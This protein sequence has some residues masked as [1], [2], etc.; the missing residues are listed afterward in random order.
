MIGGL[1]AAFKVS[2]FAVKALGFLKYLSPALAALSFFKD[3]VINHWK[4]SVIVVLLAALLAGSWIHNREIR[5]LNANIDKQHAALRDY[6][7]T[8]A[9]NK[10][11]LDLC[12]TI[13]N[14]NTNRFIQAQAEGKQAVRRLE[15]QLVEQ[16]A[17]VERIDE[18]T[19]QHRGRDEDCRSL[20]DPLPDWFDDWLR[21]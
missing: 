7:R 1:I 9:I 8:Y 11:S 5:R 18:E 21:E 6:D 17:Q 2:A 15:R 4:L 12:Y 3:Y 19:I 10:R 20:D 16:N 14:E 13:N